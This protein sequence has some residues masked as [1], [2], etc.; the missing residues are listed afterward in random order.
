MKFYRK[1]NLFEKLLLFIGFFVAIFGYWMINTQLKIEGYS[2]FAMITIFLW[3]NL[4]IMIILAATG[5]NQKEEL[6]I[7]I[8]EQREEVRILKE[9]AYEQL[10]ELKLLRTK[11]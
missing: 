6:S 8:K 2:W 4:L 11:K 3:L 9:I 5:E 1:Y 10:E 7:V